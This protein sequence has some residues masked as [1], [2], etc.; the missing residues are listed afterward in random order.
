MSLEELLLEMEKSSGLSREELM[1]KI[2][3]KREEFSDLLTEE[4][5]AYL[6]ANELGLD[7]VEKRRRELEIKNIVPG[8]KSVSFVGRVFNITPIINFERQDG[9][10]GKVVN[11]FVG[12]DTGFVRIPLWNDQA[13]LVE[14][15]ELKLGD[16]V[17]VT[18]GLAKEG[19][20]GIEV[21]IGRYGF[22]NKIEC[23]SLPSLEYLRKKHLQQTDRVAIKDLRPGKAEIV[24]TVVHIFKGKFF[25]DVCPECENTLVKKDQKL[26]CPQHGEVSPSKALLITTIVDDGTGNIR[27][28]FFR[29]QAEKVLQ[30]SAKELEEMDEEKRYEVIKQWLLGRE[31]QLTGRVKKNIAFN[32][33]E[34]I[35][36]EAKDLNVI[37]ESKRLAGEIEI[38]EKRDST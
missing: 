22:I 9:S 38:E 23:E 16:S 8:M 5:A 21:S 17:Q 13:K 10:S 27:A 34:F 35:V 3:E 19:I 36:S 25:F 28:V 6:V 37:E 18:N 1:K 20:Y 30:V 32:R 7:L 26:L 4:G 33:I 11:I 12:D 15:G 24:A 29:D 14:E 31:L 2:K